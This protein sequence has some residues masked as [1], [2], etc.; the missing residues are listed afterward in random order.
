VDASDTLA[1][2]ALDASD[3]SNA[4]ADANA[5]A[6]RARVDTWAH[7][8]VAAAETAEV[9]VDAALD[10]AHKNDA[11]TDDADIDTDARA[12]LQASARALALLDAFVTHDETRALL[13]SP[14]APPDALCEHLTQAARQGNVALTA[15]LL[16]DG[17][18]DP[19]ASD[20]FG[21]SACLREASARG[22]ANIVKHGRANPE[23]VYATLPYA[24]G[25]H[26][27]LTLAS[28]SGHA[29]VVALLLNCPAACSDENLRQSLCSASIFG[30]V[31]IV[32]L[33]LTYPAACSY[34]SLSES[35]CFASEYGCTDVVE[36]FL[37]DGR[38]DP[39]AETNFGGSLCLIT[40]CLNGH[41]AI[42]ERL[43]QD[44]RADPAATCFH[45]GLPSAALYFACTRGY[46]RIVNMLLNDRR[47]VRGSLI[48]KIKAEKALRCQ[49]VRASSRS[50]S[51]PACTM[52]QSRSARLLT[53]LAN[54]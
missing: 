19:A 8:A 50:S 37:Q 3:A 15:L 16:Q 1:S 38:A 9:R 14:R 4:H 17:R 47:A 35:L 31:D 48:Q 5:D 32:R 24:S 44:G 45:L 36:L 29:D 12:C 51:L 54:P 49:N 20:V 27:A 34:E 41:A 30:R 28:Q 40:A 11:D 42:V 33:L 2:D 23:T 46:D 13:V 18:A 52:K 43:L 26:T 39:M 22:H 53:Q 7:E 6:W 21:G 10:H 25:M